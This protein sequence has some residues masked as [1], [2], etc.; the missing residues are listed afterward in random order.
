VSCS[1]IIAKGRTLNWITMD[2][3]LPINRGT[4][5]IDN[6]PENDKWSGRQITAT[7]QNITVNLWGTLTGSTMILDNGSYGEIWNGKCNSRG[8]G[9]AVKNNPNATFVMW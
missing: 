2:R 8:I 5:I 1:K 3:G 7:N 4:L 6:V 9:G